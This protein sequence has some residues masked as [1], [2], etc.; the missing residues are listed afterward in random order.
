MNLIFAPMATLSHEAFRHCIYRFGFC[1][2]YYTEMIHASSL[3]ANG[4]FEKYY[5]LNGPEPDKI[6]W[7]LTDSREKPILEAV[8]R[9]QELGGKGIDLNMGCS[10][11]EI[12]R[13]GSGIA[14][15]MKDRKETASLVKSVRKQMDASEGGCKRLSVKMRLGDENFTIEQLLSFADM[16]AGE[17]VQRIVLHPR[18]RRQTYGRSAQWKYV[19]TLASHIHE[20]YG[21]T[22]SVIGNGD[23]TNLSSL[24]EKKKT[25]PS[26]DGFMIGRAAVQKPW[27]FAELSGKSF[28]ADLYEIF[29]FFSDA[30]DTY[31]P[32]EFRETRMRRFLSYYCAN[33]S[34]GHH[35]RTK[36]FK[37]FDITYQK[38]VFLS[39]FESMP[40][41]QYISSKEN[42]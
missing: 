21:K 28:R 35:V 34:F 14:W 30:L 4:Q 2:E 17:G 9:V 29:C 1:T 15:M 40:H 33:F 3:I 20:K 31:Q 11:P 12:Y 36:L 19:E 37:N 38:E 6:V 42:E 18:T 23:I 7:Q 41:E 22:I 25:S 10:A 16:L 24:E 5:L 39:Y 8:S 26:A 32:P 13:Q 27:I